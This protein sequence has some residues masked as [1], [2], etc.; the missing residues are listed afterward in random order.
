MSSLAAALPPD[1]EAVCRLA[2]AVPGSSPYVDALSAAAL[3]RALETAHAHNI[4]GVVLPAIRSADRELLARLRERLGRTESLLAAQAL[5]RESELQAVLQVLD[6]ADVEAAVLKGAFLASCVYGDFAARPMNDFD[7]LVRHE[8]LEGAAAALHRAG[9]RCKEGGPGQV[10][11]GGSLEFRSPAGQAIELR[12]DLTQ[13]TRLRGVVHFPEAEMWQRRR[14]FHTLAGGTLCSLD[15]TDH[16]LYL[17]YHAGILHLFAALVWLVDADRFI[18]KFQGEVEWE[19]LPARAR[20]IGCATCLWHGLALSKHLLGTPVEDGALRALEPGALRAG[21]VR[22]WLAPRRVLR[23]LTPPKQP[24][25]Q[26]LQML[27]LDTTGAV[28]RSLWQGLFPPRQWLQWRYRTSNPV[29]LRLLR[30]LYPFGG[31]SRPPM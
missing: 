11:P 17:V 28:L 3:K 26:A 16:L 12:Y 10:P 22:R 8:D 20:K 6:A 19:D 15:P 7:L 18:R 23:G 2:G 4:L 1:L 25:M 30:T 5:L 13:G 14:T 29:T 31:W 24:R 21:L 27:L 9:Y